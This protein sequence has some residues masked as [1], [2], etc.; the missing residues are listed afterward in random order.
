MSEVEVTK[1]EAVM[2]AEAVVTKGSGVINDRPAPT[3]SISLDKPNLT[4]AK[5]E[6][7]QVAK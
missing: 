4:I 1:I 7:R 2:P 3:I 6:T 5:P